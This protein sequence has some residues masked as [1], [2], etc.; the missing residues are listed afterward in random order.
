MQTLHS[1]IP[2]EDPAAPNGSFPDSAAKWLGASQPTLK[3]LHTFLRQQRS[4]IR[5]VRLFGSAARFR[6]V[7]GFAHRRICQ[8]VNLF[9]P[10]TTDSGRPAGR[11]VGRGFW[12]EGIPGLVDPWTGWSGML[13]I[14]E[15]PNG[16][17]GEGFLEGSVLV[18][19]SYSETVLV[20]IFGG[21]G[22]I[23]NGENVPN[24]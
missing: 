21:V 18:R 11:C 12:I 7:R 14:A 16:R 10:L 17:P 23:A 13:W 8:W 5:G 2:E 4:G 1:E 6:N 22:G 3:R 20:E 15:P 19:Q 9:I 24:T